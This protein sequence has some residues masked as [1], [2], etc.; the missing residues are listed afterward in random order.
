[1]SQYY[2]LSLKWTRG[3]QLT[4]WGPDNNGYVTNLAQAG[5]YSYETVVERRSYYDNHD[6]SIAI[7]CERADAAAIQVVPDHA[8]SALLRPYTAKPLLDDAVAPCPDC[9][10]APTPKQ[11]GIKIDWMPKE[12]PL[13]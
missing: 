4:W 11:I 7:P 1:M 10:Q 13:R 5:K 3:N 6:T 2:I 12:G 9:G 8:L